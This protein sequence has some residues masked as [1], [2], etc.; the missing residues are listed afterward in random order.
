MSRQEFAG[1]DPY[2]KASVTIMA[3]L[4]RSSTLPFAGAVDTKQ[5]N[6]C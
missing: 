1:L 4:A 5:K 6:D 2:L 3:D